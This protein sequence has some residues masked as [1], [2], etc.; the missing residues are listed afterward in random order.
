[1]DTKKENSRNSIFEGTGKIVFGERFIG[2]KSAIRQLRN[3]VVDGHGNISIIGMPRVG[4]TSLVWEALMQDK[5]NLVFNYN[6]IPVFIES[7]SI[8]CEFDYMRILINETCQEIENII[9]ENDTLQEL[10]N[11]YDAEL[12]RIITQFCEDK[13]PIDNANLLKKFFRRLFLKASF[14]VI[15]ILDEFDHT[16]EIFRMSSFQLLRELSINPKAKVSFVTTSRKSI[17]EIESKDGAISNFHGTFIPLYLSLFDEE[18][19]LAYWNRIAPFV[20]IPIEIRNSIIKI[21]GTHP[22]FLDL[23]CIQYLEGE[24]IDDLYSSGF[25]MKIYAE[26]NQIVDILRRDDLLNPAIQLVIG[27]PLDVS[28]EQLDRLVNFGIIK[29]V[30][31]TLKNELLHISHDIDSEETSY[32]LFGAY[33]TI[34]FYSRFFLDIPYWP[35][36]GKTENKLREVISFFINNRYGDNWIEKI[37]NENS[38]DKIW[39]DNWTKIKTRYLDNKDLPINNRASSPIDFTE[40][41]HIYYQFIKKYWNLWFNTVFTETSEDIEEASRTQKKVNPFIGWSRRFE[42]LIQLRRPFAHNNT[43]ILTQEEI[44]LG[45][46]Y[47]ETILHY[48]AKWELNSKVL[49]LKYDTITKYKT[50]DEIKRGVYDLNKHRVVVSSSEWKYFYAVRSTQQELHDGAEVEFK[51]GVDENNPKFK[52]ALEVRII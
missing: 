25:K 1:M 19:M 16:Q 30:P 33:F 29:L 9:E 49:P 43:G 14:G 42:K 12:S 7:A 46:Q 47:C 2:R 35:L 50:K 22:Y 32:V 6:L 13:S 52:I 34:L 18:D 27:P 5:K 51:V 26:F 21:V 38:N 28:S 15:F 8:S 36:W 4:K 3:R 40:T 24:T 17:E 10:K 11:I 20:S 37:E 31:L 23:C 44:N 45:K 39:M 41:G 48:I